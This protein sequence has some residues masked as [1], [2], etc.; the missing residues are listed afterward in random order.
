MLS[1]IEV[2]QICPKKNLTVGLVLG[3][4]AL[5]GGLCG[6]PISSIL[7]NYNVLH[8]L[9]EECLDTTLVPEV[10]GRMLGVRAQTSQYNLLFGIKLCERILRITDNLSR[11]LQ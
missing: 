7:D 1:L 9:W 2:R 3:H 8:Q 4:S 10:K 6:D 5:P 11:T